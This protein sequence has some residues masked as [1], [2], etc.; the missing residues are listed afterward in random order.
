M[1]DAADG[2]LARSLP[3]HLVYGLSLLNRWQ[4]GENPFDDAD[5]ARSWARGDVSE[6][7]WRGLRGALRRETTRWLAAVRAPRATDLASLNTVIGRVA[8]LAYHLGAI[9]QIDRGARGP[10]ATG[11]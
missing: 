5:W 2:A 10:S 11:G 9:R 1:S 3:D 7:E 6:D 8:H 4:A